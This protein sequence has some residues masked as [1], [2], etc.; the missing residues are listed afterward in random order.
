MG[1]LKVIVSSFSP[2]DDPNPATFVFNTIRVGFPTADIKVFWTGKSR[3]V[4]DSVYDYCKDLKMEFIKLPHN[5]TNDQIANEV[6]KKE[7]GKIVLCDSD[8]RFW[9]CVENY[10]TSGSFLAG[11]FIPQHN[12]PF[13]KLEVAARIHPSLLFIDNVSEL[14]KYFHKPTSRFVPV[15]YCSPR[16]VV[17]GGHT[18]FHDSFTE[19]YNRFGARHFNEE[20]LDKYDHLFAS[21]F[22][23]DVAK[24]IPGFNMVHKEAYRNP[25]S[26]RGIWKEQEQYFERISCV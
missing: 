5:T 20:M 7:K 10:N 22:C 12:C 17:E 19:L 15:D 9:S 4:E 1:N 18:I 6:F 24:V 13:I 25:E 2:N 21:S 23:D 14:R 11:R 26:I 8:I 16:L 3:E